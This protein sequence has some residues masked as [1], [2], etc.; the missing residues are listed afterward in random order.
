M[1]PLEY[2]VGDATIWSFTL[3]LSITNLEALL[4]LIYEVHGTGITY[5]DCQW[6][7][8]ICL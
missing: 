2:S 8:V 6:T 5:D 1:M 7:I 3:E 4:T